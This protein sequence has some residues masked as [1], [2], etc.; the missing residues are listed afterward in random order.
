MQKM[1]F[2]SIIKLSIRYQTE[3]KIICSHQ[4]PSK[5]AKPTVTYNKIFARIVCNY[6]CP[7]FRALAM[8]WFRYTIHIG[9]R[10]TMWRHLRKYIRMYYF[11]WQSQGVRQ[12]PAKLKKPQKT[13]TTTLKHLYRVSLLFHSHLNFIFAFSQFIIIISLS[14]API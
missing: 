6:W 5:S 8:K 1:V 11:S 9:R 7:T 2:F 10:S 3:Q 13:N 14:L 12:K 4:K